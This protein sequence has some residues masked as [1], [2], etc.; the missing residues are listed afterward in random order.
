MKVVDIMSQPAVAVDADTSVDAVA[1][2]LC[3]QRLSGVPVLGREGELL[4]IITEED[5][6]VR[7]A[8][9]HLPTFLNFLA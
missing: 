1:R 7:N 5:L 6:I 4:G 8:N 9:L 2:L 3:E